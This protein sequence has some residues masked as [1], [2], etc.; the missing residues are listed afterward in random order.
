MKEFGHPGVTAIL[1][2]NPIIS[3]MKDFFHLLLP[4]HDFFESEH[5]GTKTD[6]CLWIG[7]FTYSVQILPQLFGGCRTTTCF[8]YRARVGIVQKF[9]V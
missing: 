9:R 1:N 3:Q 8:Y 5:M 2:R 7:I 6:C 4:C